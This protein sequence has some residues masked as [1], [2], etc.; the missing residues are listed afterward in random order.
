MNSSSTTKRSARFAVQVSL[1]GTIL[2]C[3]FSTSKAGGLGTCPAVSGGSDATISVSCNDLILNGAG[4]VTVGV[5][6]TVGATADTAISNV[7][8]TT[9]ITNSGAIVNNSVVGNG[10]LNT[11]TIASLT[12]SGSVNVG[13][14]GVGIKNAVFLP[15]PNNNNLVVISSLTN[16][17]TITVDSQGRGILNYGVIGTLTNSG[18][19]TGGGQAQ[20]VAGTGGLPNE[21]YYSTIGTLNNTGSIIVGD[22]GFAISNLGKIDSLINSGLIQAGASAYGISSIRDILTLNNSGRISAGAFGVAITFS[23]GRINA[24]TNSGTIVSGGDGVVFSSSAQVSTIV[25]SGS[26]TAGSLG[27]GIGNSAS[28]GTLTNSGV[29]TSGVSGYGVRNTGTIEVLNNFGSISGGSSGILSAVS[30]SRIGTI[31]NSQGAGNSYGGLVYSGTLPANYNV[32]INSPT[33]YGQL[34]GTRLT[35]GTNTTIFGIYNT[36]TVSVGTYA[37]VLSGLTVNNFS[38]SL[39]GSYGGY[40]WQLINP[41]GTN[42]DLVFSSNSDSPTPPPPPPPANISQ[43]SSF[44]ISSV[45]SSVN[46]VFAGGT[47]ILTPGANTSLPFTV[48][49]AGGTITTPTGGTAT[50]TGGLSGSGPMTINGGGTLNLGGNNTFTGGTTIDGNTVVS[51][52]G[53]NPL[54]TGVVFVSLGSLLSGSGTIGAPVTVAGTLHPGNSPGYLAL[55][56]SLTFNSGAT[57]QQDIAGNAQASATSPVGATGYYSF[58]QITGAGLTI[59]S[60]A[61]LAPRLQNL[62]TPS[63]SGYGSAQYVPVVGER[64]RILTADGGITG[65]FALTQPAGMASGTQ[66]L[67]FY[68]ISSS[69][70]IDLAVAPS[71]YSTASSG[72]RNAQSVGS[73]LDKMVVANQA[74]LSTGTQDALL[75]PVSGQSISNLGS[76]L[77]GMSGEIYGTTLAVVPQTTQRLQAAVLARLGDSMFGPGRGAPPVTTASNSAISASNPGGQPTASMSSNPNVNPYASGSGGG[78]M[79]NGAAWGEVAYQY[80]NRSSDSNSG[81]WSSNLVQAVVGVDA[82]VQGGTRAGGGLAL[83]N[84]N[85][86]AAQGSGTVQQGTLFLYGK[87]PVEQFV[88]DAMASYGF[89][90]TNNSRND[91]TGITGGLQAKNVQGNDALVSVGLSLPIETEQATWAPYARVTWQ[92][93]TQSGFNEGD[94]A[95][96][97]TVSSYNGNGVRGVVGLT[98][99]SKASDPLREQYTYKANIGVGVDSNGVLSP[100]LNASLAGQGTQIYTPNPSAVFAQVGVYATAK[101]AD[102]AFAYAGVTSELRGGQALVGG[103]VGVMIQF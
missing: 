103:N 9:S 38:G 22:S 83:S 101:V 50:M 82:F 74:G 89:N 31:N 87:M 60:G 76:Y 85:V 47:L 80:G 7:G 55:T 57:Y 19:I 59:N 11:G 8:S 16:S 88:V 81:G 75:Y 91:P 26:I 1:G 51:I 4:N 34:V 90:S 48:T 13:A 68:N 102:T 79:R 41:S 23:Y 98:A 67:Q 86:T 49:P 10:V 62:F 77:Q 45:G 12:N 53:S 61:T 40:N 72:N 17:G 92:N 39:S 14:S 28:I 97:L 32:V 24:L 15:Q 71:S 52:S 36:S 93:V 46:P 27:S 64:F 43:G 25:N 66:F 29:I 56:Q 2:L 99:G 69:N 21:S 35:G 70:S 73:A 6:A 95:S 30:P 44:G 33:N 54:G 84:T 63:E 3:A 42:W 18:T 94:K 78:S 100:T 65:K 96:A 58:A 5:G 20:G 37:S